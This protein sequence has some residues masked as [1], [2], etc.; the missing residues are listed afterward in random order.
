MRVKGSQV[1]MKRVLTPP[2]RGPPST[3]KRLVEGPTA[4][5]RKAPSRGE[6]S[7]RGGLTASPE[8]IDWTRHHPP[9]R[10]CG[11]HSAGLLEPLAMQ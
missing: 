4:G 11:A 3:V 6:I 9:T 5:G 10:G 2:Q 7:A 1:S 8:S